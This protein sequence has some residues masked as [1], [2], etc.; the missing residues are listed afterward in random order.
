LDAAGAGFV[1]PAVHP[2][3]DAAPLTS[4]RMATVAH[5]SGPARKPHPG[6]FA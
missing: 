4:T 6:R 2:S 3:H 5:G 1:L